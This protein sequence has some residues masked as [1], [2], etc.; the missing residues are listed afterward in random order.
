[1][2]FRSPKPNVTFKLTF[3]AGSSA[4]MAGG[5]NDKI[6]AA[7]AAGTPP[8]VLHMNRP[9]EFGESGLLAEMS[10]YAKRDKTFN[11]GDFFDAPW[12]RC[13]FFDRVWGVPVICDDRG[14]WIN[15][16]NY[17]EAGLDPSKPPR[18]WADMEQAAQRLTKQ[19]NGVLER[20]GFVPVD[21]GNS[22]LYSWIYANGGGIVDVT[23]DKAEIQFNKPPAVE[24]AEWLVKMFDRV[25]GYDT[26][27]A[28][29]KN[30]MSGFFWM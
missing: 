14:I 21:I 22:D 7:I 23:P 3:I 17:L 8:D 15:K 1:M 4:S 28:F 13:T 29:K 16:A 25:G 24:A 2:L 5:Y 9:P 30:L 11:T 26:W 10:G 6:T 12:A 19:T 27:A 20:V 18:T